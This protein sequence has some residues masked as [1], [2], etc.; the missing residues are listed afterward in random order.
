MSFAILQAAINRCKCEFCRESLCLA[1]S[2]HYRAGLS[3]KLSLQCR[4]CG[5]LDTFYSSPATCNVY[6]DSKARRSIFDNNLR[7]VLAFRE[8]GKGQ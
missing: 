1:D 6:R 4:N 3:H 7:S 8:I 2:E 5:N